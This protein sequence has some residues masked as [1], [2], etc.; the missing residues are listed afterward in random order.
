[1]EINDNGIWI[2]NE[3]LEDAWEEYFEK[4]PTKKNLEKFKSVCER[5]R[6]EWLRD[7]AKWIAENMT[8]KESGKA[9]GKNCGGD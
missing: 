9:F 5:D 3:D 1:M 2:S 6:H 7:N 8:D 4:K